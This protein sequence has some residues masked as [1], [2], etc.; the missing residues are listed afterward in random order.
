[1]DS[2]IQLSLPSDCHHEIIDIKGFSCSSYKR[3]VW[4]LSRANSNYIIKAINLFYS[5]FFLS[6]FT[7][8]EP[9]NRF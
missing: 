1:M 6:N 4:N 7:E 3:I 8:N 5:E 9:W 2:G